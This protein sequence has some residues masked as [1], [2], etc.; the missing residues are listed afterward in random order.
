M[1]FCR[2]FY[3]EA[4]IWWVMGLVVGILMGV[5]CSIH[6]RSLDMACSVCTIGHRGLVVAGAG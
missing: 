4:G 3:T 1:G 5:H 2:V 6:F